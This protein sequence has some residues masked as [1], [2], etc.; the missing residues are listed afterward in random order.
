M[1]F[2]GII[3]DRAGFQQIYKYIWG[4][5]IRINIF[6]KFPWG[7]DLQ[8]HDG[9]YFNRVSSLI[10]MEVC[11]RNVAEECPSASICLPWWLDILGCDVRDSYVTS[12]DG[13]QLSHMYQSIEKSW[14]K[15]Y[16]QFSYLCQFGRGKVLHSK[17]RLKVPGSTSLVLGLIPWLV[18]KVSHNWGQIDVDLI[19][20]ICPLCLEMLGLRCLGFRCTGCGWALF[21]LCPYLHFHPFLCMTSWGS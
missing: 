16:S 1:E 15:K 11:F 10:V 7:V 8:S 5:N 9:C 4:N 19:S 18:Q 12:I 13:Q 17:C 3:C 2:S 6:G 21:S 20:L 14:D